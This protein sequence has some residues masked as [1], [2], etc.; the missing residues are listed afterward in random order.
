M[1]AMPLKEHIP[2]DIFER[3]P[4]VNDECTIYNLT[5]YIAEGEKFGFS[6]AAAN[7]E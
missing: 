7:S 6:K 3:G 1:S 4:Y 2:K 5:A